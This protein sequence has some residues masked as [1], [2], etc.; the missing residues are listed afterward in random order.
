MRYQGWPIHR[1]Q[2][3]KKNGHSVLKIL[4][5]PYWLYIA[6][7]APECA[8]AVVPRR[9]EETDD[10][11][12]G[13]HFYFY[14]FHP[15]I[16]P[17]LNSNWWNLPVSLLEISSEGQGRSR[18]EFIRSLGFWWQGYHKAR[19]EPRQLSPTA[20]LSS[21]GHSLAQGTPISGLSYAF[22]SLTFRTPTLT[23]VSLQT[24]VLSKS[25]LWS[26]NSRLPGRCR[27]LAGSTDQV[28]FSNWGAAAEALSCW[29]INL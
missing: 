23:A 25:R 13:L 10:N 9:A 8:S 22:H 15:R 16:F 3:T 26:P 28:Q 24:P 12:P 11:T 20:Y 14:A 27:E 29:L 4:L 2:A 1:A 21:P 7:N 18:E 19:K 5:H 6:Q 17:A